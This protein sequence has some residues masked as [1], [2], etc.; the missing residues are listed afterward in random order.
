MQSTPIIKKLAVIAGL[1]CAS[2][3]AQADGFS[4]HLQGGISLAD[5]GSKQALW[6]SPIAESQYDTSSVE[7]LSPFVGLGVAYQWDQ[8]AA[9]LPHLAFNL[10]LTGYFEQN[11]ISGV[12]TPFINAG[13]FPTLNYTASDR[14]LALMLEPKL[15]YTAYSWQPYIV[16]GIG[17][18]S[19]KV[20]DYSETPTNPG[21]TS[22]SSTIFQGKTYTNLAYE[23]GIGMQHTLLT[24]A[25]G[26]SLIL[27]VE[28][29]YMNWGKMG[30]GTA[31][32]QSTNQG[33][34][35]GELQT[36]LIDAGLAW[37]F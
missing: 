6:L 26:S 4:V 10:G 8:L 13:S 27:A 28:Y 18:A 3:I 24:T 1:L 11:T 32:G 15:I 25:S 23:M 19:N 21:G 16:A 36:N 35:F 33:P 5:L 30:L 20:N 17:V 34:S 12:N 14:S 37:Q 31:P 9:N 7:T 2:Q 29:K 22:A